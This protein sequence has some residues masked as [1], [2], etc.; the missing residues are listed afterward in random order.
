MHSPDSRCKMQ[1]ANKEPRT[2]TALLQL[3]EMSQRKCDSNANVSIG[4]TEK[5]SDCRFG[6]QLFARLLLDVK[7]KLEITIKALGRG[8]IQNVASQ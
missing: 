2:A 7:R 8:Q 6:H 4:E 1:D 5:L 3:G